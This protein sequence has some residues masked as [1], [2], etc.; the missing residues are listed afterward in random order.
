MSNKIV[1]AWRRLD[2]VIQVLSVL[3]VIYCLTWLT[4]FLLGVPVA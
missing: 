4:I 3:W 1:R 2:L